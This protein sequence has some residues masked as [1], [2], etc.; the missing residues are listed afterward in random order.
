MI[1]NSQVTEVE[2]RVDQSMYEDGLV[3]AFCGLFLITF[4]TIFKV[5]P[6]IAGIAILSIFLFNP[7]L[8]RAKQRWI[9][10]RVGYMKP[11]QSPEE[12]SGIVR[13]A[14][15]SILL[16]VATLAISIQIRGVEAGRTLFLDYLMPPMAG[17]LLAIGP[18]WMAQEKHVQRGYL[19][20]V[21][22][23]SFGF[24]MSFFQFVGGYE[25]VALNCI[26]VGTAMLITG[27]AVFVN[28]V[29]RHP[30]AGVKDDL[31]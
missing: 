8:E 18:W 13:G 31:A 17:I 2:R 27:L 9:Y 23:A 22:F 14:G 6:G 29:R 1:E 15:L 28:F 11:R 20:A 21:M 16:L 3:E 5:T 10:P 12:L 30:V 24:V 4:G 25:A 26:V 7:L 19:W